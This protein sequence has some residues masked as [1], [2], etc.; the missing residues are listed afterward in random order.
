MSSIIAA[1]AD[2]LILDPAGTLDE[3][4]S[5]S[6]RIARLSE[7]IRIQGWPQDVSLV[8]SLTYPQRNV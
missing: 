3:V 7:P 6:F 1:Q 5:N 4:L 2:M 8:D